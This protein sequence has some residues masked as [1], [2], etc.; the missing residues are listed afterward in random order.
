MATRGKA[1]V[2]KPNSKYLYLAA[3][4]NT[5][6]EPRTVNQA[7]KDERWRKAMSSE[8]NAQLENHTWD[9]VPP[10]PT[11]INNNRRM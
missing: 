8:I 10:P 6:R 11:T 9:I 4:L 3:K 7:L 1:G 5:D 2:A